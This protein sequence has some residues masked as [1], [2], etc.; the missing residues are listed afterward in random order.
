MLQRLGGATG[1]EI[2][3][4][5]VAVVLTPLLALEGVTVVHMAGLVSA[6]MFIGMVLIPPVILKLSSTGYRFFRY[7]TRAHAYRALGPP[8]LPLR[9]LAPVLV[10]SAIGIFLTGVLLLAAGHKS[11]MLLELH[12]L[13]FIVLGV[14]FV[15]HFVAYVPR[16][17]GSMREDWREARRV[18]V[19]G[20]S[21]RATLVALAL[22]GGM[23]LAISLLHAIHAWRP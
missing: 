2:L 23:A 21:A 12:K 17:A 9:L 4:S 20:S 1:N 18:A 8:R 16:V 3:T 5:A 14:L 11:S 15:P 22:G 7:Y 13:S 10:A 6:H 19:P